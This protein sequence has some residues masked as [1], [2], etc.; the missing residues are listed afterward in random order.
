M[1]PHLGVD[2]EVEMLE[3]GK[4]KNNISAFLDLMAL[5]FFLFDIFLRR[6]PV[7]WNMLGEKK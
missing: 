7:V 3:I 1:S 5:V 2:Q 6:S 4:S